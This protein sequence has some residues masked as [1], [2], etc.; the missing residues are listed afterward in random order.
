MGK[1]LGRKPNGNSLRSLRQ[2]KGELNREG[3]RFLVSAVVGCRPIGY[4]GAEDHLQGKGVNLASMYRGRRRSRP[5]ANCPSSLGVNQQILLA[6]LYHGISNRGI[7]V[8]VI[9]HGVADDIGDLVVPACPPIPSSNA[10]SFAA[11]VSDHHLHEEPRAPKL[12]RMRNRETNLRTCHRHKWHRRHLSALPFPEPRLP[13][14]SVELE[15]SPPQPQPPRCRSLLRACPLLPTFQF[16]RR[17]AVLGRVRHLLGILLPW[18]ESPEALPL[19]LP[20]QPS[21]ARSEGFE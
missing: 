21:H 9:L 12:R 10:K 14:Q 20:H 4:L 11:Q 5:S 16:L 7:S 3:N 2:Q 15:F 6:K 17:F 8:G 18:E 1:D 13:D 19:P